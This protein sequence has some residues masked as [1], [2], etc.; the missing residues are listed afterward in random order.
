MSRLPHPPEVAAPI[1]IQ[2]N[3]DELI[4]VTLRLA[5][6]LGQESSMLAN[7][8]IA[9]MAQLHPEKL[10]L[11]QM[12]EA[13]Q[14]LMRARPDIM[15]DLNDDA[16]NSLAEVMNGFTQVMDHN[17]RQVAAARAVN[18]TVVRAITDSIAEQQHLTVYN[19]EG[20]HFRAGAQM[21]GVSINLNQK[22]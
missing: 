3:V 20:N 13:Y 5:E 10:K 22:A 16:R 21:S 18:Q 14:S 6:I 17:F 1:A 4:A 15:E 7:M 11:T 2:F 9:S 12:L 19:R 8:E